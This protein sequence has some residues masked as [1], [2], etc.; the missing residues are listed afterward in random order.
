M[1]VY[2]VMKC[3]VMY[4]RPMLLVPL[5]TMV[6]M[7]MVRYSTLVTLGTPTRA[8]SPR[9]DG[10]LDVSM[11]VSVTSSAGPHWI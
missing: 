6:V 1:L 11:T 9:G 7:L 3:C 10:G 8:Q 5:V 4:N 2:L